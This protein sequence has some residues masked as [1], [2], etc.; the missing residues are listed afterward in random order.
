[1][2]TAFKNYATKDIGLTATVV[3]SPTT[4]GIQSTVIGMTVANTNVKPVKASV[5]LTI[6]AVTTYVIKDSEIPVGNALSL[7]GE[8]KLILAQGNVLEVISSL[9]SSL[10]V[11]MSVVEVV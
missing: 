4:T 11:V 1:M 8:G 3:Y 10:D 6:G 7:L 9:A 5:T 2:A